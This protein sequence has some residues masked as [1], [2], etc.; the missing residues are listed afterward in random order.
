VAQW[1]FQL[2]AALPC[3][4]RGGLITQHGYFG[5]L[6]ERKQSIN[7][8]DIGIDYPAQ[9]QPRKD[10]IEADPMPL[11]K[12]TLTRLDNSSDPFHL[13]PYEILC[14]IFPLLSS[15]DISHS[16]LASRSFAVHATPSLLPLSFWATRFSHDG[17]LGFLGL[18]DM[19]KSSIDCCHLYRHYRRRLDTSPGDRG[20]QNRRRIW[21]C[22]EPFA[23]TLAAILK[24]GMVYPIP[25]LIQVRSQEV[26]GHKASCYQA[27]TIDG[28][29]QFGAKTC[30]VQ[31]L[32]LP[33]T[34][35][36]AILKVFT[37][38][39]ESRTYVCG[40]QLV[41]LGL[42]YE[43]IQAVGLTFP[44]C[45]STIHLDLNA[46][47][48]RVDVQLSLDGIHGLFFYTMEPNGYVRKQ[49]AG[50]TTPQN[51]YTAVATLEPY[52][53]L[54]GFV[55]EF[56]VS[57]IRSKNNSHLIPWADIQGSLYSAYRKLS[58]ELP[59]GSTQTLGYS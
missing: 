9:G 20:F 15:K 17:E 41:E 23:T 26:V 21:C 11:P 30:R 34:S 42:E 50:I 29:L 6:N 55:F 53:T 46:S 43:T 37:L 36:G 4:L 22:L 33:N 56:D 7:R 19:P 32:L 25:V 52:G 18:N 51:C 48:I 2:F 40:L 39:F 16:R 38:P 24:H 59:I 58:S 14:L 47:I 28:T 13:L 5:A 57:D 45:T 49:F 10:L 8:L 35:R 27:S 44:T 1:L 12:N 31:N 54:S 3:S